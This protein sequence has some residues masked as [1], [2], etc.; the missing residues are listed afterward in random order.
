MVT[1]VSPPHVVTETYVI[2]L[3]NKHRTSDSVLTLLLPGLPCSPPALVTISWLLLTALC[4]SSTLAPAPSL[5]TL[6][7]MWAR[8]SSSLHSEAC[9][10]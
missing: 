4:T 10:H 3:Y 8:L 1:A 2:K 7:R 5:A 9:H 6:W